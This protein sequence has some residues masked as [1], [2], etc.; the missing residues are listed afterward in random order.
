MRTTDRFELPEELRDEYRR[1]VRLTWWTLA[2]LASNVVVLYLVM[3]SSQAMKTAWI[4]DILSV[5]PPLSFLIAQRVVRREP[6]HRYPYGY[7]RAV[8]VAFLIGALAL[9]AVGILLLFDGVMTLVRSERPSIGSVVL[10]GRHVWLGWPMLLALAWTVVPLMFIG[11]AKLAPAR[12]LHDKILYTDAE[13]NR[14]NWLTGVAAMAG[15][16]GIALGWWWADAV[17]AIVISLDIVRDGAVN[18]KAAMGDIMDRAPQTVDHAGEIDL[19]RKVDER[20]RALPWVLDARSRLRESGHV[21]F[22]DV[23]VVP[24]DGRDP[25]RRVDECQKVACELDWR[26]LELVVE[27][28]DELPPVGAVETAV[29]KSTRGAIDR[30]AGR[31][32]AAGGGDDAA[33]HA[34]TR[35][36]K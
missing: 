21:F 36:A 11:H 29:G 3:G 2:Y 6:S 4:E 5:I 25:T 15:I 19:P 13:M 27:L 33:G 22:G 31:R 16:V 34:T 12:R 9:L 1:A 32:P 17:A 26:L 24:R 35:H 23:L 18:V 20:L 7:H 8:T 14:A 30:G 10:M 28:V